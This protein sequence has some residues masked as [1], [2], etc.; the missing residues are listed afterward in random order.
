MHKAGRGT[1]TGRGVPA[2]GDDQWW[3]GDGPAAPPDASLPPTR[4]GICPIARLSEYAGPVSAQWPRQRTGRS[5]VDLAEERGAAREAG[6]QR[7]RRSG[8]RERAAQVVAVQALHR[9]SGHR[10]RGTATPP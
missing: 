4:S 2:G 8:R 6:L 1:S 10:L 7:S 9:G 5:P 3:H